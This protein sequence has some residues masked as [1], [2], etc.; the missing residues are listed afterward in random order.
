[1]SEAFSPD[2]AVTGRYLILLF[3]KETSNN[4]RKNNDLGLILTND[5]VH[6]GIHHFMKYDLITTGPS[7]PYGRRGNITRKTLL[8]A[9]GQVWAAKPIGLLSLGGKIDG[10]RRADKETNHCKNDKPFSY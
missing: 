10:E 4:K 7:V 2:A 5:V 9:L 3:P 6:K 1:V 8:V